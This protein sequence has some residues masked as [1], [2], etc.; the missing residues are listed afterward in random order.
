MPYTPHPSSRL[1][2]RR[3]LGGSA[4]LFGGLAASPLVAACSGADSSATSGSKEIDKGPWKAMTWEGKQ[5]MEKWNLHISNFF[6]KYPDMKPSVDYGIDW[7]TYWT[8]L[9]T[10]VAGGA[11]PDMAWM[12]DTRVHLF[13]SQGLLEPL[14]DYLKKD[15]PQGW[16]DEFF[17]SQVQGFQY[18]GKQY[19]FPYDWATS[20][21][22][23]NLDWLEAAGVEVPTEEWTYDQLMKAAVKLTQHAGQS[24]KAWGVS[25]PTDSGFA[26]QVIKSYGGDYVTGN[27]L[28]MHF[29]EPGTV[30][31]FQFLYDAIWKLNA[32]P[33]PDQIKAATGGTGDTVAFFSSGKVAMLHSLNDAAFAVDELVKGKFRWTVAPMPVGP[34]GRFQ[35]VGGSAFSIPKGS[36]HP[37]LTYK[38][39]KWTLS[40]PANLPVTAKMG[41]MFVSNTKYAKYGVPDKKVLDPEVYTH[42]FF[43][44]GKANSD[45]PLYWPGYGRW[46]QSVYNKNM[47]NLWSN[48][49]SDVAGTLARV[50]T[51]TEPLLQQH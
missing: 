41:S 23:I 11:S 18:D 30:E 25:L 35:G 49:T 37:D 51:E 2:R 27:D 3:L 29:T 10:T 33:N 28:K 8:K 26:H 38:F 31:G 43:D 42:T 32:M 15:V 1:S 19:G 39:I 20:G 6:K 50:Q 45:R 48:Q 24:G 13:A 36:P 17:P 47:D 40:D 4:A 22:Y 34:K 5:E 44:L 46:D 9:Q 12:H 14:D 7:D 16:P 21:L